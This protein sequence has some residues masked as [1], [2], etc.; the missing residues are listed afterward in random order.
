MIRLP[1]MKIA[2][3]LLALIA[4]PVGVSAQYLAP[5]NYQGQH[6]QYQNQIN[7]MHNQRMMQQQMQQIQRQQQQQMYQNY[8]RNY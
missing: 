6:M 8:M 3:A 2:I 4:F 7:N 1:Q 5:T